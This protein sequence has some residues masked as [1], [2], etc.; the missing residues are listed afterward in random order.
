MWE[1]RNA[2][3]SLLGTL[4]GKIPLGRSGHRWEDNIRIDLKKREWGGFP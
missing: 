1:M 4:E 3:N 2:Y